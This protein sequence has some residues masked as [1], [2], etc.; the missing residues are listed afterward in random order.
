MLLYR[1]A[2]QMRLPVLAIC[3]GLQVVNVAHGGTLY[4]D[5]PSQLQPSMTRHSQ[6]APKWQGVHRITVTP[7]THTAR[8][9]D[10]RLD[11]CVNSFHHQAVRTVGHGLTVTAVSDDGL[12]EGLELPDAPVVA[13]QY[14]PERMVRT[15][16]AQ[17]A[18]FTNWLATLGK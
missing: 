4:Q 17:R 12:V 15:D 16:P 11:L 9:L 1:T 5:L 14:H 2:L 18:L 13:V 6:T 10:N 8:L 3:R 7:G